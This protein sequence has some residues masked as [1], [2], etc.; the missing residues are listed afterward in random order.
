MVLWPC[1]G[2]ILAFLGKYLIDS[3]LFRH[4]ETKGLD[5]CRL[6]VPPDGGNLSK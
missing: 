1:F 6:I 3:G 2:I 5:Q 4:I